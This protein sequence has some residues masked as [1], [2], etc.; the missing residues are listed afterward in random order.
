MQCSMGPFTLPPETGLAHAFTY[1]LKLVSKL[2]EAG[3]K[4]VKVRMR[5]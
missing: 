2:F 3:L 5:I 4:S 1:A